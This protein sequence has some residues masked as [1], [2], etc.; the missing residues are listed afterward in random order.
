MARVKIELNS[1]G[2]QALLKSSEIADV[3]EEQAERMTRATG[4]EYVP[5][6]RAGKTRISARG[7]DAQKSDDGQYRRRSGGRT[8]YTQWKLKEGQ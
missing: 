5:D 3:C 4:V 6:V 1:A 2:I 7:Y 8:V